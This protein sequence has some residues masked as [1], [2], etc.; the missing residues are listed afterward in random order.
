MRLT[1]VTTTRMRMSLTHMPGT[2][3][4]VSGTLRHT[5]GTLGVRLKPW[6]ARAE[7]SVV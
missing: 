7:L 4:C 5:S 2:L 1:C 6:G 3:G